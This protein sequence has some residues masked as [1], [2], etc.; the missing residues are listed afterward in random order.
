MTNHPRINIIK[1]VEKG[2]TLVEIA[3]V[4]MIIGLLIGGVF[5]GKRLLETARAQKTIGDLKSIESSTL[6]FR[7]TYRGLPG[8]IT[9]PSARLP[10]CTV[11][12]C[13]TAG[14]NNRTIGTRDLRLGIHTITAADENFRFWQHLKA[15]DLIDLGIKNTT[16]INF[17]QGQPSSDGGIGG[18][19]KM[20]DIRTSVVGGC[21]TLTQNWGA[22]V[23]MA[24]SA[25]LVADGLP[26]KCSV[27][28][29]IDKKF[30]DGRP[31]H[32]KLFSWCGT[33]VA[34]NPEY[35]QAA[36]PDVTFLLLYD[37]AGF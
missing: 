17:G 9:N 13:S 22:T 2:F 20:T 33:A 8:D 18:G 30:D 5:G 12:P 34:C 1:N 25:T 35:S 36:G 11:A 4:M 31:F 27:A 10:N 21:P 26:Y 16:D 23:I 32:G 19:Y 3:I 28:E 29:Y 6:V 14:N 15:S 24:G 37:L 7:D